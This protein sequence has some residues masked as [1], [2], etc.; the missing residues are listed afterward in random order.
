MKVFDHVVRLA[1]GHPADFVATRTATSMMRLIDLLLI[2]DAV[3]DWALKDWAL[4]KI[5]KPVDNQ[6]NGKPFRRHTAHMKCFNLT[7][8]GVCCECVVH[9]Y[10]CNLINT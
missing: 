7:T 6:R 2:L 3:K 10:M 5:Q 4:A 8:G 1:T 9:L